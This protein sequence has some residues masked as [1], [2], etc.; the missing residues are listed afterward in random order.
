MPNQIQHFI[1]AEKLLAIGVTVVDRISNIADE[2]KRLTQK[3]GAADPNIDPDYNAEIIA[4]L[5]QRMDEL[6]KKVMGIWAQA[7]VHATLATVP[8]EHVG[9]ELELLH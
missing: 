1:E 4:K 7:Q 5:T 8:D 6:G 9:T 3:I 2:R